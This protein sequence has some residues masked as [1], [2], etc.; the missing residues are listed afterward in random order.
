MT[1]TRL[2]R[3]LLVD[4]HRL[5]AEAIGRV[6]EATDDI[7]VIG[8]AA[9]VAD[10]TRFDERP[11]VVLMDYV[12]P[13]GSGA[14]ATRLARAR[15][16]HARVIMLTSVSADETILESVRAGADGYLTKDRA[17]ADVTAAVRAAVA[18]EV[19]L[20]P[21][22]LTAIAQRLN[23]A[24]AEP[25]VQALTPREIEVLR[26]LGAGSSSG[27]IALDLALSPATVRTHVEAI[28][29]KLGARSRLEAVTVA[30]RHGLIQ[31]PM[32]RG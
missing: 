15:W 8:V 30:L 12:L 14:E 31:P 11:D 27:A 24:Q 25:A 28:R 6:L 29:R 20:P 13:D 5:V 16:P 4:D 2:I 18:G 7:A 22:V 19:L 23:R 21:E 32:K 10:L 9:S 17:L 26:C 1:S 3:V